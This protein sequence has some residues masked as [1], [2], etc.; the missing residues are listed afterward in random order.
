MLL[1]KVIPMRH[2]KDY[3]ERIFVSLEHSLTLGSQLLVDLCILSE[4]TKVV[5]LLSVSDDRWVAT[6]PLDEEHLNSPCV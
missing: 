2:S 4:T 3:K 1:P 6:P 5:V